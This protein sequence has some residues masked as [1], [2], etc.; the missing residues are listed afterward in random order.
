M[1]RWNGK[2]AVVTG[3]SSG[4]GAAVVIDL[5]NA[6]VN[7]VGL[8][9]REQRVKDLASKVSTTAAGKLYAIKCDVS[10]EA[11]VQSAFQWV[12]E[13][14]GG[15]SV[16]VNNAGS[17]CT[18]NLVDENN[19]GVMKEVVDT[20]LWGTV[21][22][23]REAFQSMKRHGI[24]GHLVLLNSIL[25]QGVPYLVGQFP[26]FNIYPATKHAITAITEVLRQ[27]LQSLGTKT[28]VTVSLTVH[29]HWWF[30]IRICFRRASARASS[31]RKYSFRIKWKRWPRRM[32]HFWSQ[33]MFP[34]R[35]CTRWGRRPTCR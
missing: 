7:V 21:Y 10:D 35:F 30:F 5:L 12:E 3:A 26:S 13:N 19:T 1:Q 16:L 17:Q 24:D 14:V 6:G 28:K 15:V 29:L 23:V 8:A 33:L 9:R 11:A 27:E 4:I 34:K 20:N 25:G 2:V 31:V 32:Y 22:C 18:T